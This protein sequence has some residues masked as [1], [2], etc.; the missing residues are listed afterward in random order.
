MTPERIAKQA[1][2]RQ[3]R[4][5]R[6][7][8]N[9]GAKAFVRRDALIELGKTVIE[10]ETMDKEGNVTK[11]L[12]FPP[13]PRVRGRSVPSLTFISAKT[14]RQAA[15]SRKNRPSFQVEHAQAIVEDASRSLAK[16]I[17]QAQADSRLAGLPVSELPMANALP[18]T[19][20]E[21]VLSNPNENIMGGLDLR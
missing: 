12:D 16:A 10:V 3:D 19:F 20:K 11:R 17:E 14:Y 9:K 21:P 8:L 7:I 5:I 13:K 4:K 6:N 18:C 1:Q 15:P 2:K